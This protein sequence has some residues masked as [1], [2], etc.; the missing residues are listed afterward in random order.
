LNRKTPQ[1]GLETSRVG[2]VTYRLFSK[3]SFTVS[4][5]QDNGK[6]PVALFFNH[7][8]LFLQRGGGVGRPT[9]LLPIMRSNHG[10]EHAPAPRPRNWVVAKLKFAPQPHVPPLHL[11]WMTTYVSALGSSIP[12]QNVLAATGLLFIPACSLPVQ[13]PPNQDYIPSIYNTYSLERAQSSTSRGVS[14][15]WVSIVAKS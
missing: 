14:R 12:W 7:R 11:S 5:S 15:L 1:I 8:L 9:S 4:H 2:Y 3:C 13:S 10:T 6:L